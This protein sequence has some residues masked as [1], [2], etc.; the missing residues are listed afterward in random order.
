MENWKTYFQFYFVCLIKLKFYN[1]WFKV[2]LARTFKFI[3]TEDSDTVGNVVI[4]STC[5]FCFSVSILLFAL[6]FRYVSWKDRLYPGMKLYLGY[7]IWMRNVIWSSQNKFHSDLD[8]KICLGSH[9]RRKELDYQFTMRIICISYA[10][11]VIC[12]FSRSRMHSF[13]IYLAWQTMASP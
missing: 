11:K 6:F 8:T 2:S 3:G 7:S 5:H 13:S 12:Y 1:I 9:R 10:M 4:A